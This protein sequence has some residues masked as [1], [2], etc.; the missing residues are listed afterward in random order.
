MKHLIIGI[1]LIIGLLMSACRDRSGSWKPEPKPQAPV[2]YEPDTNAIQDISLIPLIA[3]PEKYDGK[4]IRVIG[5][6]HIEFEGN[7]LS[8][9]KKDYIQDIFKNAIWA[10]FVSRDEMAKNKKF[11]DHYVLMEGV[12]SSKM[13]GHMGMNS[14]SIKQISRLELWGTA[15]D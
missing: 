10:D 14:G 2:K 12:F 1:C 7:T 9:N 4:K 3:N 13:K 15:R 8:I 6:L 11:S 5:Y